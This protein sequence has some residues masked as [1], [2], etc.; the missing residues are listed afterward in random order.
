[1]LPRINQKGEGLDAMYHKVWQ[2]SSG[3]ED[4]NM[5]SPEHRVSCC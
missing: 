5:L 3:F 2:E 4:S 1:M